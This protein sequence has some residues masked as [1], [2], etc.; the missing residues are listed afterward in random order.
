MECSCEIGMLCTSTCVLFFPFEKRNSLLLFRNIVN[1]KREIVSS[2]GLQIVFCSKRRRMTLNDVKQEN[3]FFYLN[4]AA[5]L[6]YGHIIMVKFFR[7]KILNI[8]VYSTET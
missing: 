5:L 8:R 3:S 2:T 6:A 1:L 7:L 4:L